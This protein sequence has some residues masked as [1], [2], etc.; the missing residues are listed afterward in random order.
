[1]LEILIGQSHRVG[2]MREAED[3]FAAVP[4]KGLAGC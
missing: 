3:R 1:M 4:G 2:D